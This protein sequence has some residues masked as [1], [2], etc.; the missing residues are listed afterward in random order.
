MRAV[1]VSILIFSLLGLGYVQ[2][3]LLINGLQ[4]GKV[5]FDFQLTQVMKVVHSDLAQENRLTYLLMTVV[6]KDSSNFTASM[7]TITDA[8]TF[9][10][11]NYLKNKFLEHDLQMDYS[12]A[13]LNQQNDSIYL[14]SADFALGHPEYSYYEV[15]LEG[16][17]AKSCHCTPILMIRVHHLLRFL[18]FQLN[19][20]II[21][22]LIFLF[23]I[24][25][26]FIWLI[27]LLSKVRR[28]DQV[29]ND[30]I[31]NLTHEIKTPVFSISLATKVL[32]EM[33]L[34]AK[35]QKYLQLIRKE[36]EKMKTHIEAVLGLATLEHPQSLME[37]TDQDVHILLN[38]VVHYFNEKVVSS[39]GKL[40][41][42]PQAKQVWC[43]IHASHLS[44]AILN[45]LDNA[46]K[47]SDDK[48]HLRLYTFNEGHQLGI[49]VEDH[50]RGMEPA[51]L[52]RIFNKFY[53]IPRGNIHDV[54][55]FGLGLNYVTQVVKRHKGEIK[56]FSSPG[57]GSTFI[58][59]LLL[60]KDQKNA[61][62]DTFSGRQ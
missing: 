43:A 45:L 44:N 7:D 14:R 16:S 26:S 37:L 57:L 22:S 62:S 6:T 58:I 4:L 54:K 33:N 20:V 19:A 11:D 32:E 24:L 9:Y 30:F 8:S 60:S 48:P 5:K 49:A 42:E 10:L 50:G 27:W 53:R 35:A 18:L 29:K 23:F 40:V 55:G 38:S 1:I 46:L 34:D 15:N 39:E 3:R 51:E 17:I 52:K 36:N 47:Y 61:A 21:P 13:L 25:G 31:N 41:Y 2:F 28:L 12:F 59:F 56:V